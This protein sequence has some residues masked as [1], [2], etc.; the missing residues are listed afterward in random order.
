M[1]RYLYKN[2]EIVGIYSYKAI[3]RTNTECFTLCIFGSGIT[4][5]ECYEI[6]K[7]QVDYL[8]NK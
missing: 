2:I 5:K 8:N 4:K 7:R 3:Y 1:K 6:A